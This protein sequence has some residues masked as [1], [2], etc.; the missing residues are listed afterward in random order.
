MNKTVFSFSYDEE[1]SPRRAA[2][3]PGRVSAKTSE[4]QFL[5]FPGCFGFILCRIC[6]FGVFFVFFFKF[7]FISVLL[8]FYRSPHLR[9]EKTQ[10]N[11]I[12]F[13]FFCQHFGV[14]ILKY[15]VKQCF[16]SYLTLSLPRSKT[17]VH[18]KWRL[19]IW[20]ARD[21]ALYVWHL[22]RAQ[23][24]P[25]LPPHKNSFTTQWTPTK[26]ANSFFFST[27]F[28]KNFITHDSFLPR[29]FQCKEGEWSNG[30]S[31]GLPDRAGSCQ[32]SVCPLHVSSSPLPATFQVF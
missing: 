24:H 28:F 30:A 7:I 5:I 15:T 32:P 12:T 9:M 20:T 1:R 26:N 6:L 29:V 16:R 3:K 22:P 10:N 31:W 13:L 19:H 21:T 2:W 17:Q 4:S 11:R 27:R 25:P 23:Y 14:I 18:I 8:K